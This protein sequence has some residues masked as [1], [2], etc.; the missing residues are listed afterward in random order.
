MGAGVAVGGELTVVV[1]D[2]DVGF[3]AVGSFE[4]QRGDL[5][6]GEL[7]G[8]ADRHPTAVAGADGTQRYQRRWW[9]AREHNHPRDGRHPA[10]QGVLH[11]F[12]QR[13]SGQGAAVAGAVHP[14]ER[15]ISVDPDQFHVPAVGPQVGPDRVERVQRFSHRRGLDDPV[16]R[17]Q[18]VHHGV[19]REFEQKFAAAWV[20]A[21]RPDDRV[22]TAAVERFDCV[23]ELLGLLPRGGFQALDGGGR[24][25]QCLRQCVETGLVPLRPDRPGAAHR[26]TPSVRASL[27]SP[28]AREKP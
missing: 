21:Q 3:G 5:L 25:I 12:A 11:Y 8:G 7:R 20:A 28:A 22:D 13:D 19:V 14:Q 1:D 27:G 2:H 16:D 26:R 10:D 6:V 17:E 4:M 24:L 15:G 9:L 23:T 18:Q